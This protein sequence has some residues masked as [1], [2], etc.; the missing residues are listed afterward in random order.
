[1]G[2]SFVSLTQAE[3]DLADR[4]YDTGM[5]FWT[6]PELGAYLQEALRTWNA[7]TGIQRGD[8]LFSLIA[9]QWWYDLTAQAN[10][11]RPL[12]VTDN[13]IMTQIEY[14]LLEP[15]T[16]NYPLAWTG[17][18]QFN[19]NDLLSAIQRRRDETLSITSCQISESQIPVPVGRVVL[20]DS[21]ID[22]RRVAWLPDTGL[23]YTNSP[24]FPADGLE[25]EFFEA[26]WTIDAQGIPNLWLASSE[27]PLSFD[28]DR[29]AP[30]PGSFDLLTVN[31]GSALSTAAPTVLGVPDDWA[32]VVKWGALADL[33]SR[34]SNAKDALRAQ[35]AEKR[36]REGLALLAVAPAVLLLRIGNLTFELDAV[37][38]GDQFNFGWQALAAGPPQVGYVAG[39]NLV[40]FNLPDSGSYSVTAT[41][42][43]NAPFVDGNGN[44]QISRQDY[45]AIIDYAQHLAAFKLG[46]SEFVATM[47]L[48][49]RFLKQAAIYNSKLGQLG[50]FRLTMY[51]TSQL[52]SERN[53][54]LD[55]KVNEN[56]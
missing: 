6:A 1:M 10:S 12:T 39:L 40:A 27:P 48:Y 9:G 21:V 47:P 14:H 8:F 15:L 45:D 42:V 18:K 32:W 11:I 24:L 34:E 17:S 51:E 5:Q 56:G 7:L 3:A 33:L 54:I 44:L 31:T 30:V 13:S 2:Y 25:K 29:V 36:Y 41:V 49:Q 28:V 35:Y 46:G 37:T 43:M 38:N 53:P 26:G 20:S 23:G 16:S 22:V 52:E 19:V 50:V 55:Q 4:L